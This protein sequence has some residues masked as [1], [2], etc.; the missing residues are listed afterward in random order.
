MIIKMN[1]KIK[2]IDNL[3]DSN[4]AKEKYNYE[5]NSNKK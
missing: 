1:T 4:N 2:K 3:K 5:N